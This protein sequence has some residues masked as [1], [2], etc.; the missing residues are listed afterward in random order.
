[1]IAGYVR[2]S[3]EMQAERDSIVNQ[4]ESIQAFAKSKGEPVR[5]YKD[6]G[7]S[8]KDKERPAFQKLLRAIE[9]G[10]IDTVVVTKLDRIT[11]SV[12]DLIYLKELF[13]KQNVDFVCTTQHLDTSTPMGRLSDVDRAILKTE[14]LLLQPIVGWNAIS[15]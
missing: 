4:E 1:M 13:D 3:T 5:L 10:R 6:I 9:S 2:V 12:K 11:R 14:E 7:I 15:I 8:G